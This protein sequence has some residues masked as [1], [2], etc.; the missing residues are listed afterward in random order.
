MS[1]TQSPIDTNE[2]VYSFTEIPREITQTLKRL[3]IVAES[4]GTIDGYFF[5][6][7][8]NP[9]NYSSPEWISP[10]KLIEVQDHKIV[11]CKMI[12][13]DFFVNLYLKRWLSLIHI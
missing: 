3:S 5:S 1:N 2:T 11:L 13:L 8:V 7:P 12:D 10:L 9:R 6:W 4:L